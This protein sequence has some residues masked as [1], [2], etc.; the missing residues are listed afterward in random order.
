MFCRRGC[1]DAAARCFRLT[2]SPN[3]TR[4]TPMWSAS[5]HCLDD[6]LVGEM[7]IEIVYITLME[8]RYSI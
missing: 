5:R 3:I 7:I 1:F 2:C 6:Q 8:K 4:P